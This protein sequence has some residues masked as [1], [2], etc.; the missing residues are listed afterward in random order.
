MAVRTQ[1]E[2]AIQFRELHREHDLLVL[3]NAWDAASARILEQV[4]FHAVATTSS[5]VAASLGYADGQH[6]SLDML[7]DVV[8][9]I[10]RV[11]ACPVSVDFEAGYG[12]TIEEVMKSVEAVIK[13]GA[14]G[15]NIEDSTKQG[16]RSLV[17]ITYQVELIKAIQEVA[18]SMDVP[19]VINAR[20]DVYLLPTKDEDN[21]FAQ[22]VERGNAYCQAGADCIF[23]IG[24]NDPTIIAQLVKAVAGPINILAGSSTPTIPELARLGVARVTFG[25]GLMRAV[26]GH[27]Q[28]VAEELFTQGT[29]NSMSE[30]MLAANEFRRLFE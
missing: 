14:A 16:L 6:I 29:Y 1:K 12:N 26:M 5:G 13:A 15:I 7:L 19:L 18:A 8:E 9:R 24:L 20:T 2:K 17:D 22:S 10:T 30:H 21:H 11:V 27:L 3:P 25:G 28:V 23:P 4:G